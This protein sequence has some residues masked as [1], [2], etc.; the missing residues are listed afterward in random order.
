MQ[1]HI[2]LRWLL[3][4]SERSVSPSWCTLGFGSQVIWPKYRWSGL[5]KMLVGVD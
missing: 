5:L 4:Q 2:G 1:K 3:A